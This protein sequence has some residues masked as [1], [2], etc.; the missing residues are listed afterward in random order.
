MLYRICKDCGGNCD[1]G[2]MVGDICLEC[3]EQK[4]Q[5]QTRSEHAFRVMTS[6]WVQLDFMEVLHGRKNQAERS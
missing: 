6:P 1:P 3:M 4:R 2:D 5:M